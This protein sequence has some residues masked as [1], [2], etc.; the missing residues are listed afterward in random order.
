M[1]KH[2]VQ[3]MPLLC[4]KL[5]GEKRSYV[6]DI[7]LR[8]DIEEEEGA[9]ME[10]GLTPHHATHPYTHFIICSQQQILTT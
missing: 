10:K 2:E 6:K 3:W 8:K 7:V 1:L 5:K 9:R 4:F